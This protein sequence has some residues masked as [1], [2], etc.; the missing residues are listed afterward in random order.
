MI[1]PK[2][3]NEYDR[4]YGFVDGI[5]RE[6]LR[7]HPWRKDPWSYADSN[8]VRH[9]VKDRDVSQLGKVPKF[10]TESKA[11]KNKENQK[12]HNEWM[13]EH[14]RAN[15]AEDRVKQ[16]E[17]FIL[18]ANFNRAPEPASEV[19]DGVYT[20]RG[21]YDVITAPG[22]SVLIPGNVPRNLTAEEAE[23][24]AINMY[25]AAQVSKGVK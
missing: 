8:G 7:A 16:L 3:C 17:D 5:E 22:K 14:I 6:L 18:G 13:V 11:E 20:W 24:F 10:S 4:Y 23:E 9:W 15:A 21:K 12:L 2:L 19:E 1:D 25:A